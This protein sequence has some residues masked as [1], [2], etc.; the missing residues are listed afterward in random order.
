MLNSIDPQDHWKAM[1]RLLKE[2]RDVSRWFII[3]G[4]TCW[5][6]VTEKYLRDTGV[7]VLV[8]EVNL[9]DCPALDEVEVP[10][11]IEPG[12]LTKT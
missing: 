6:I 4:D 8:Q 9:E 3:F 2:L 7:G 11:F 5:I 1:D 12:R 10:F